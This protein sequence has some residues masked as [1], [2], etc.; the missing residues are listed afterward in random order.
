MDALSLFGS[1]CISSYLG[2]LSLHVCTYCSAGSPLSLTHGTDTVSIDGQRRVMVID[3]DIA[4]IMTGLDWLIMLKQTNLHKNIYNNI[5]Y[6]Y[7]LL[8]SYFPSLL[9]L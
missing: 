2:I 8:H 7:I 6:L 5:I 1:L 9:L 4:G 3:D